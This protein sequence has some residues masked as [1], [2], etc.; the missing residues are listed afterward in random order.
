MYEKGCFL[1]AH[2]HNALSNALAFAYLISKTMAYQYN[3]NL[4]LFI[5]LFNFYNIYMALSMCHA[6]L[7]ALYKYQFI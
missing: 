2:Q 4:H 3:F 5:Y 6:L 1:N 7:E